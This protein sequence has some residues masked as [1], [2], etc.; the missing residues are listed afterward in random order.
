MDGKGGGAGKADISVNGTVTRNIPLLNITYTVNADC[1]GDAT[2]TVPDPNA[3]QTR[4]ASRSRSP[5]T[6]VSRAILLYE[7]SPKSS[8]NGTLL[9][10]E[11]SRVAHPRNFFLSSSLT[12][13]GLALPW[14]S[15]ITWP[16]KKPN[17]LSLPLR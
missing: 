8:S 15:F 11:R 2:F 13:A 17:N 9:P 6:S 7:A 5:I 16:T 3:G 10:R 14:L 1:T 4:V 12:W